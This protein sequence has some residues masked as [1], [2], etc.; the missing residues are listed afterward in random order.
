LGFFSRRD[1]DGYEKKGYW[2][3]YDK[4]GCDKYGYDKDGIHKVT[5]TKLDVD[6]YI[7]EGFNVLDPVN[8]INRITGTEFDELGVTR[9]GETI[10]SKNGIHRESPSIDIDD[11]S[12]NNP[13]TFDENG[14]H[15]GTGTRYDKNGYDKDGYDKDGYDKDG[16]NK[17]TGMSFDWNGIDKDGFN[18]S[19]K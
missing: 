17:S 2:K 14:I 11:I 6:G 4:N 1:K 9:Y 13:N 16:I 5:G 7:Q 19:W 15:K 10:Y 12:G 3:R 18:A 8:V